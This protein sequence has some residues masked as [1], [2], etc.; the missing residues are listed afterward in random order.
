MKIYP[1]QHE[2]E[3]VSEINLDTDVVLAYID[4]DHKDYKISVQSTLPYKDRAVEVLPYESFSTYDVKLFKK[5]GEP[6]P[7][8]EDTY[9]NYFEI[10]NNEVLKREDERYIYMPS[11]SISFMPQRFSYSIIGKKKLTYMTNK[12]YNLK[13]GCSSETLSKQLIKLFGAAPE[14]K[15]CPSNIWVNNKDVSH[16]S[17]INQTI[18]DMD[19]M[20]IDSDNG[21][22]YK[23]TTKEI[24]K[25]AFLNQSVNVW[26]IS[27][28]IPFTSAEGTTQINQNVLYNNVQVD[29]S[30]FLTSSIPQ[31][32]GTILH[33]ICSGTT[34]IAAIYE[35]TGKAFEIITKSSLFEH[36]DKNIKAIYEILFYVYK[37]SYKRTAPTIDW[38]TDEVPDYVIVDNK[39]TF[40][41]KFTSKKKIHESFSLNADEIDFV[42]VIIDKDNVVV[43]KFVN[44]YIV[45]KKLYTDQYAEFADPKR[46]TNGKSIYTARQNIVYFD[47]FVYMIEEDVEKCI[48]YE[49]EDNAYILSIAGFKHSSGNINLKNNGLNTIT[50][51][52]TTVSNYVEKVIDKIDIALCINNGLVQFVD[53]TEY[54]GWY[55]TKI[56]IITIER[57]VGDVQIFD[58]RTRGGGLPEDKDGNDSLLDIGHINGL[59]YR[60]AGALIFTLPKRLEPH[61]ELILKTIEKHMTSEK[62]PILIFEGDD[63]K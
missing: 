15:I 3:K 5:M 20:F 16:M 49:R 36:I 34:T 40:K 51:P 17:L 8:R 54:N 18:E 25:E 37:M 21:K 55:G 47:D 4:T 12:T 22:C 1:S 30:L 62:Y 33:H 32:E 27:D 43:D 11:G 42:D 24:D 50:V 13:V 38:I 35:H 45:F 14:Q 46:P 9:D 58:M 23:R 6:T 56:C 29:N 2:V 7:G 10:D 28:T 26:T 52:L 19:F 41:D 57:V 53:L 61:K 59:A 63:K 44:N 39:L 31:K 60:K 48:T